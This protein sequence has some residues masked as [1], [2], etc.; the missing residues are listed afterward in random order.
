MWASKKFAVRVSKIM[1][2]YANKKYLDKIAQQNKKIAKKNKNITK[3]NK[4]ISEL[5]K[6]MDA[7]SKKLDKVLKINR[8]IKHEV[9][10]C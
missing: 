10:R 3:K 1:N 2:S 8:E 5:N 4:N 6:K 7:Q 9:G